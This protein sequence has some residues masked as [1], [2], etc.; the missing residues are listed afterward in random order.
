MSIKDYI[1]IIEA[2]KKVIEANSNHIFYP[3]EIFGKGELLNGGEC[4]KCTSDDLERLDR[5]SKNKEQSSSDWG[6]TQIVSNKIY[7]GN[8]INLLSEMAKSGEFQGK[9]NLIYIDPPFFT[10]ANYHAV[11]NV[12]DENIKH[13][14]YGD[15][16]K[17]GKKDY[18]VKIAAGLLLMK[19]I[20]A[21]DGLIWIHLDW[22]I[23]HYVKILMDEIFGENN[24]VNEIIWTYKSGGSSRRRFSRKHDNLLVYSKSSKYKFNPLKEKS[25]NRQFKPYKFKGIEEFEDEIGWYTLVN[26]KDVWNIDVVGRTSRER[27]G[28]ATQKPE[29]LLERIISASTSEG[30]L[31]GDFFS[32]SGT[33]AAACEN[34]GRKFILCDESKLAVE[35]C[36]ERMAKKD[37]SFQVFNELELRDNISGVKDVAPKSEIELCENIKQVE[38]CIHD[39]TSYSICPLNRNEIKYWSV[40]FI[41]NGVFNEYQTIFKEKNKVKEHCIIEKDFFNNRKTAV[42]IVDLFGNSKYIELNQVTV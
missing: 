37:A 42:K 8:N 29:A 32:G 16:W 24:F 25:Y 15:K 35:S 18:L 4:D 7:H 6:N 17:N 40:G 5:N 27:T 10:K 30:D 28:Y 31:C 41:C 34:L 11:V 13:L 26:M 1:E 36:I 20:L 21:E 38:V 22:H 39:L 23:V 2:A 19:E 33:L 3:T 14:A 9:F 12:G